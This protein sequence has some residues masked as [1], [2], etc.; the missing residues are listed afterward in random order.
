MAATPV[1]IIHGI[2]GITGIKL[3]LYALGVD[4]LANPTGGGDAMTEQTNRVGVYRA[5]VDEA[6]VGTYEAYMVET[7]TG[8]VLFTGAVVLADTTAVCTVRELGISD[9]TLS[10]EDIQDIADGVVAGTA[11]TG[12]RTVTITVNDGTT[13]L[14]GANVRV[15]LNL[16][17][18]VQATNA[19][20]QCT[21]NL[22]DGTWTVGITLVNYTYSGTTLVVNGNETATYSMTAAGIDVSGWPTAH[23]PT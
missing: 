5:T 10:A 12:A 20:G 14:Q 7:S 1:D 17:T 22:D 9:V 3:K 15:T 19:S 6:L 2:A 13:A 18:Y 11:G 8:D 4:T 23:G 16:E 21:F